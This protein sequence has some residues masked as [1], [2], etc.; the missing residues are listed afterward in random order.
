M[1]EYIA[2]EGEGAYEAAEILKQNNINHGDTGARR[3]AKSKARPEHT[4]V[5]EATE[6]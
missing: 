3:K 5:A 1:P 6:P 2:R 4:E